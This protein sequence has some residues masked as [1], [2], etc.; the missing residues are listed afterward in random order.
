M[1]LTHTCL[2]IILQGAENRGSG[3]RVSGSRCLHLTQ[4]L[5]QIPVRRRQQEIPGVLRAQPHT[6]D[7]AEC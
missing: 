2:D 7:F 6:E 3:E 5:S 1:R 4:Q